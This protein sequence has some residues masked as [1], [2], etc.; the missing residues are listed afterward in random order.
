MGRDTRTWAFKV[1]FIAPGHKLA[2]LDLRLEEEGVGAWIIEQIHTER[3]GTVGLPLAVDPAAEVWI[4]AR[5]PVS[6]PDGGFRTV[7]ARTLL[8]RDSTQKQGDWHRIPAEGEEQA[9][10]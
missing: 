7:G 10:Q 8:V 2:V 6:Y 5:S 1:R 4:R 3:G 9:P